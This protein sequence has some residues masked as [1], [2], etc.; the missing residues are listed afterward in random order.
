MVKPSL[1]PL[2]DGLIG[3]GKVCQFF[4]VNGQVLFLGMGCRGRG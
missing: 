2:N 3:N 1:K 4:C